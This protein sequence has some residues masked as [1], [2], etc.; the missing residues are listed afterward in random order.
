MLLYGRN[1]CI[2]GGEH[3]ES[4]KQARVA[5]RDTSTLSK[6]KEVREEDYAG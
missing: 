1:F 4:T 6:G 5:G 2:A 3:D